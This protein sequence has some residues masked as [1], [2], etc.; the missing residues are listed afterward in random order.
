MFYRFV[1]CVDVRLRCFC[2]WFVL[3]KFVVCVVY[4]YELC[5]FS[6]F[7]NSLCHLLLL[8]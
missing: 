4:D 8:L 2:F 7:H 5:C 6:C 3:F 1:V